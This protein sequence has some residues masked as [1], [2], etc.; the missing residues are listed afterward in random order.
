VARLLTFGGDNGKAP[1]DALDTVELEALSLAHA[2]G[3]EQDVIYVKPEP[4]PRPHCGGRILADFDGCLLC[5]R[6]SA[7]G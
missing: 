2:W 5:A 3:W 7:R 4:C 1:L 6:P